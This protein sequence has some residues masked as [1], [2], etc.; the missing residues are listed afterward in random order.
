MS[1]ETPQA[2]LDFKSPE[3]FRL[4]CRVLAMRLHYLNRVAIGEQRFAWQVAET[5]ERLGRVFDERHR[6]E[7]VRRAFGDGWTE[8]EIG[9]DAQAAALFALLYPEGKIR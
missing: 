5:L 1:D 4:A 9:R 6:D 8:G 2:R 7:A 3:E